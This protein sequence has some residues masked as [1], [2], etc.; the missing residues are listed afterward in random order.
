MTKA[1]SGKKNK[2]PSDSA[3]AFSAL[4]E[5]W[6]AN[7]KRRAPL[8]NVSFWLGAGFATAWNTS[9]PIGNDLFTITSKEREDFDHL[10][11]FLIN[12]NYEGLGD[13]TPDRFKEIVYQLGMFRKYPS[14]RTRYIDDGNITLIEDEL[15]LLI[16][17][18][19]NTMMRRYDLNTG[20]GRLEFHHKLNAAQQEIGR[21]FNFIMRQGDG[22]QGVAEGIRVHFLTTNFDNLIETIL[23]ENLP[24]DESYLY[25]TYRGITPTRINGDFNPRT[26]HDNWIV[27]N[28]FKVNGGFEIYKHG[29][30]YELDYRPPGA[31][32]RGRLAPQIMLPSKEQDY[33]Q[34]YFQAVF[35]KAIRLLQETDVLVIVGYSLPMEDALLR[36]LMKQLAE[37]RTDG[38]GRWVFYIDIRKETEQRE[39]IQ[40]IWPHSAQQQGIT[41]VPYQG[42]FAEWATEVNRL[43]PK[44]SP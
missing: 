19:F 5:R 36:F 6:T 24:P 8:R 4:I 40:W 38:V 44:R 41:L 25:Y 20:T 32:G 12:N 33:T 1:R 11:A 43:F 26:V 2:T 13:I 22:S 31:A 15:R 10:G 14:I 29:S 34:D 30:D 18:K 42:D 37:D 23:D 17:Q 21:F 16:S 28:L 39:K 3:R 27:N 7:G 35:P 9:F